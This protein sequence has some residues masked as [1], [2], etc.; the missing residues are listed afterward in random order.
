M[1]YKL[2]KVA[3][4]NGTF[5]I[6]LLLAC[7]TGC[8]E[9]SF[10]LLSLANVNTFDTDDQGWSISVGGIGGFNPVG[11]HPGGYVY[12]DD[13]GGPAWYFIASKSFIDEVRK[14]YG[15]TL[16][17]DLQQ[18]VAQPKLDAIRDII[19]TDGKTTLYF[20]TAYNPNITWTS[21]FV[22]LDELTGWS[23]GTSLATKTEFERVLQNLTDLR[24]RGDYKSGP[25]RG[26]LDNVAIY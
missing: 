6:G 19:F 14:G 10:H 8:S 12:A 21:Y 22:K 24:I 4:L 23:N 11:G 2:N 5:F 20:N 26:G 7:S 25:V 3:F 17:F 18:A 9:F 15:K 13:A 1:V 16:Y